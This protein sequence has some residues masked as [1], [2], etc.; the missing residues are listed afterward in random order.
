MLKLSLVILMGYPSAARGSV[1]AAAP[2]IIAAM[3]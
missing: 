1:M 2:S 3:Q